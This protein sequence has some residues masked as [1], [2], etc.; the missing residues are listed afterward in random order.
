MD[1]SLFPAQNPRIE[2]ILLNARQTA[3]LLG[4]SER[5]IWNLR[6]LGKLRVV[7]IGRSTRY[8]KRDILRLI[9][10]SRQPVNPDIGNIQNL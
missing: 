1:N 9:E 2:P 6:Q 4:V 8:D 7:R 10:T 3:T 5:T